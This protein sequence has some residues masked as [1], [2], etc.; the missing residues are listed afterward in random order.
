MDGELVLSA[1]HRRIDA[2]TPARPLGG[3][4]PNRHRRPVV[5]LD[6][7]DRRGFTGI[8]FTRRHLGEFPR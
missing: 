3:F 6:V 1:H 4:R 5:G 7:V 2:T 8:L